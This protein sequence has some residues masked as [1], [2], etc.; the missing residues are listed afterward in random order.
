MHTF[1][2]LA[3]GI[4]GA[5]HACAD[6]QKLMNKSTIVLNIIII[7]SIQVFLML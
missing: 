7:H 4:G 1:C 2:V 3:I 5:G 6:V